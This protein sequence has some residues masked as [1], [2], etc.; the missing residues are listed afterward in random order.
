MEAG[1][2]HHRP[3]RLP[4]PDRF[5]KPGGDKLQRWIT[6]IHTGQRPTLDP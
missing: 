2:A 5:W 1:M 3:G 6:Q 4:L